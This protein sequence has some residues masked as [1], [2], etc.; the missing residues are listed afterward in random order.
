MRGSADA[1]GPAWGRGGEQ[2]PEPLRSEPGSL[3]EHVSVAVFGIDDE[4]LIRYWGPGA[5]NL[6]GHEAADV[7][8]GPA[9]ALFPAS[10]PDAA[11]HLAERARTLGYWRV[12]LPVR[13]RDGTVFDCG[14]RVFP[15]AAPRATP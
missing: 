1:D 6:F 2:G 15:V 11:A 5:R 10:E 7:L 12:R 4:G 9:A 8:S 3:L 13:H 14:F